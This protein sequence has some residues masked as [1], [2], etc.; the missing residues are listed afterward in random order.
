MKFLKTI[1]ILVFNTSVI[2][3][4]E[5]C[6]QH[7]KVLPIK[8]LIHLKLKNE[9]LNIKKMDEKFST[10]NAWNENKIE[11]QNGYLKKLESNGENIYEKK[12]LPN[13]FFCGQNFRK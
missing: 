11:Y 8:E 1:L 12:N 10:W 9:N 13:F 7:D 4:V 5:S 6:Y 2:K 3:Y